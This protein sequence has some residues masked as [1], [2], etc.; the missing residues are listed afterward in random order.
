MPPRTKRATPTSVRQAK[1]RV[2][3]ARH[4]Y[5]RSQTRKNGRAFRSALG[6]LVALVGLGAAMAFVTKPRKVR[7]THSPAVLPSRPPANAHAGA[8]DGPR[9]MHIGETESSLKDHERLI[10]RMTDKLPDAL[11]D[12]E[13]VKANKKEQKTGHWAWWAFPTELKGGNE[14]EPPTCVTKATAADL[15][16][17]APPIWKETLECV[18]ECVKTKG[19][20]VLPKIDHGRVQHFVRFWSDVQDKPTWLENVIIELREAY[21]SA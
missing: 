5:Q 4:R 7:N 2:T 8:N 17:N 20:H 3:R 19:L 16:A 10:Q 21:G 9:A 13:E 11:K 1:Q 14:P 18:C 12:M 6:A 15:I